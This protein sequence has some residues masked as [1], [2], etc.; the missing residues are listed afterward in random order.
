[1]DNFYRHYI[2]VD[3]DALVI[4]TLSDGIRPVPADA[5]MVCDK[6]GY[7]FAMP[8]THEVNPCLY[9]L[10]G[11]SL[12]KWDGTQVLPRTEAEIQ[13]DREALP[14]PPPTTSEQIAA[15]ET[16]LCE[17]DGAASQRMA[18]IETALCEMDSTNG[19]GI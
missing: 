1:M 13:A 3:D 2:V 12:Y 11:I 18:D 16:A 10:D 19:G 14:P 4:D 5:I 15:L 7:Q 9:T 6:G 8:G 17:Q